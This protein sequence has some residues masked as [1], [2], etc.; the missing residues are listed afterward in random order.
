MLR[1]GVIIDTS[2]TQQG[3]QM[4][5]LIIDIEDE[6]HASQLSLEEIA[7]KYSLTL[8]EVKLILEE[9]IADLTE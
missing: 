3:Q 4:K 2:T 5:D 1:N 9:M 8:E 6:L 7:C